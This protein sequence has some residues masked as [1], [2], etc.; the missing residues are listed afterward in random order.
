MPKIT[1]ETFRA[2]YFTADAI[3]RFLKA[4]LFTHNAL[5]FTQYAEEAIT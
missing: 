2:H 4:L 1:R 5:L 3:P